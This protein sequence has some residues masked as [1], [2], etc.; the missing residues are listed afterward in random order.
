MGIRKKF[1]FKKPYFKPCFN[2]NEDYEIA[3][4]ELSDKSPGK[5][6]ATPYPTIYLHS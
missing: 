4:E 2:W 3:L 1:I 5:P 6:S